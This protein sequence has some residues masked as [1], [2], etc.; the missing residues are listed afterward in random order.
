MARDAG[1]DFKQPHTISDDAFGEFQI[2][3]EIGIGDGDAERQ[4]VT[5]STTQ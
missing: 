5:V 1:F 4:L 2:F 3:I